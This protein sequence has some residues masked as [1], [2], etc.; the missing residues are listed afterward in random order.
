MGKRFE[1]AS[2]REDT[3]KANM[4]TKKTFNIIVVTKRQIETQGGASPH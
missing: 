2:Q 4:Y 3:Q 1:Q